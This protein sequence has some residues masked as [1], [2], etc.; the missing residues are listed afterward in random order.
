MNLILTFASDTY[1][2]MYGAVAK[3]LD[4]I[5]RDMN[6]NSVGIDILQENVDLVENKIHDCELLKF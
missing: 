2:K 4:H 1:V 6:R 3:R 5:V